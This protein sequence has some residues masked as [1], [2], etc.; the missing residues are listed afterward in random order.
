MGGS[1]QRENADVTKETPQPAGEKK[2]IRS[3]RDLIAWQKAMALARRVYGATKLFPK[4]ELY[5]LCQQ[6]R[7]GAVS[8][9]SNIAEGYGRGSRRD[10]VS[11]LRT[12][13]ASLY[14]V[15]T[16]VLLAEELGYLTNKQADSLLADADECSRVLN[17]LINSLRERKET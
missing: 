8:V 3:Y 10:Y 12:A 7:K 14:E 2:Q 13:R 5:G 9:P 17:G 1:R 11:F 6:L 16:Q 15:E 4:D